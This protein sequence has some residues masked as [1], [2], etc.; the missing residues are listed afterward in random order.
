VT[1][2]IHTAT[3]SSRAI[4][5]AKARCKANAEGKEASMQQHVQVIQMAVHTFSNTYE[6]KADSE[7]AGQMFSQTTSM[8]SIRQALG[9]SGMPGLTSIKQLL[10]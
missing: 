9:S 10:C 5:G 7:S 3:H 2:S 6:L 1:S 4:S 8:H